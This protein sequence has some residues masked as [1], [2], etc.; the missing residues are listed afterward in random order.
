MMGESLLLKTRLTVNITFL[1]A[2]LAI[3]GPV[4]AVV[5]QSLVTKKKNI[6]QTRP[7]VGYTHN[8][9]G[10]KSSIILPVSSVQR[11]LA[12]PDGDIEQRLTS[13]VKDSRIEPIQLPVKNDDEA[14]LQLAQ[15]LSRPG[16]KVTLANY[17]RENY[18]NGEE[19]PGANIKL[20]TVDRNALSYIDKS[21]FDQMFAKDHS[22]LF[23]TKMGLPE[24]K[25]R[26]ELLLKQL[27]PFVAPNDL[28]TIQTM[29]SKG[30]D[31]PVDQYILPE[32]A[33][34]MIKHH[35]I[36]KGPNCF[37]AALSFQSPT[38]AAS[39]LVNVRE[40][41]GYHR[42]MINYDEMWR[43]VSSDFYEISPEKTRLQYGDM[44]LFFDV[45]KSAHAAVDFHTLRHAATYLFNGYIFAKGS[46]SANSPYI[47]RPLSDEWG[48]W[49]N[50]TENLGV[51]VF[52]RNLTAPKSASLWK[53]SDWLD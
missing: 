52:R 38:F 50:Y 22:E 14:I 33:K 36:F 25:Q 53:S 20:V 13:S 2:C 26:L 48:T 3:S 43:V 16:K 37:H 39:Q 11:T 19:I 10:L 18:A 47:I 30:Q 41:L 29:A 7:T 34:R 45:P 17:I 15:R 8:L 23:L 46:K 51:K 35:S 1:S 9:L 5:N 44:I 49:V 32:F 4:A 40:E 21:S 6:T 24:N 12:I 42:S 28:K 31:I 27:K